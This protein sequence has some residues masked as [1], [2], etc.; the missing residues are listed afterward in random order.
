MARAAQRW[1]ITLL[2]GDF[3][4]ALREA[5]LKVGLSEWNMLLSALRDGLIEPSLDDFYWVGRSIL[6]K[7]ETHFDLWDRVFLTV[8][9]GGG[10]GLTE[11][12]LSHLMEWLR[13]PKKPPTLSPEQMQQLGLEQ[14]QKLFEQRLKE[15]KERH[16]GGNRWIGTGGTSPLG[17]SGFS[18][19]GMRVG[20]GGGGKSASQVAFERRFRD[21]ADDRVLD[22]RQLQVALKRLRRLSRRDADLELDVDDSIDK[23]CKNAG[24]LEL[25]FN[26]PRKNQAKVVLLMDSGGSMDPF[27]DMVEQL[28]SAASQL[29]HWKKLE[30]FTFHNCVYEKIYTRIAE[31]KGIL[32]ANFL[33][34]RPKDTYLIMVGDALMASSELTEKYGAIQYSH[35]NTVPGIVWLH[36]LRRHFER[37]VWLNPIEE[38]HWSGWTI[39]LIAQVFPMFPLSLRGL[40]R[41]V[42]H[43][44]RGTPA[45][46]PPIDPRWASVV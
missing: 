29:N 5:G 30:A 15:Q 16:D 4:Y 38:R 2:F 37:C 31:E 40:D 43:L 13:D 24:E 33:R 19:G 27:T 42:D 21:Y 6:V 9:A 18:P 20:G 7:R 39:R 45:P 12:Q 11:Q 8:F 44:L 34:D 46:L 22:T 26:P 41:A 17:H 25:V 36:R 32:T 35:Q 28:F 3:F 1:A 10:A 14:L 23:T